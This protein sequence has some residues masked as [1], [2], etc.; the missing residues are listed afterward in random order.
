MPRLSFILPVYKPVESILEKCCKSLI[1]QSLKSWEA[2]FVLDGESELAKAV[3]K[4][5]FKKNDNY[6]IIE[7]EHGGACKARNEGFKYA[8]DGFNA[9]I[10]VALE[11]SSSPRTRCTSSRLGSIAFRFATLV[12]V[13]M[14]CSF[15]LVVR[16][17]MWRIVGRRCRA[18]FPIP[19]QIE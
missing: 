8:M 3:I 10:A 11:S 7:I 9:R 15:R 13:A 12:A 1:A 14:E 4:R 6:K 5:V 18:L 17:A 16:T 19:G 2:I